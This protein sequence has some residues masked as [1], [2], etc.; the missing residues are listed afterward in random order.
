MRPRDQSL[1]GKVFRVFVEVW[2]L[3]LGGV[4]VVALQR[5]VQVSGRDTQGCFHFRDGLPTI[6][7][8]S[9]WQCRPV[10]VLGVDNQIRGTIHLIHHESRGPGM[11]GILGDEPLPVLVH[12]DP[13]QQSR[14]RIHGSC[15]E[16]LIHVAG[17]APADTP[18]LMPSPSS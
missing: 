10:H 2:I 17:R 9:Q 7:E 15:H 6:N 3:T 8:G 13:G 4:L 5:L 1:R 18:S 16:N 12:D 11:V 14:R